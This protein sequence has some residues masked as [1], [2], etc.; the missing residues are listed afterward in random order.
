MEN[1]KTVLQEILELNNAFNTGIYFVE[2][3][4]RKKLL[5]VKIDYE[6][7]RRY[8]YATSLI[9]KGAMTRE[10]YNRYRNKLER[11]RKRYKQLLIQV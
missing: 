5:K 11:T 1:K 2:Y 7:E 3:L 8:D 4:S 10:D 6:I 9:L